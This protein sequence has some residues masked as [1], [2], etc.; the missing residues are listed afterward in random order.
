MVKVTFTFDDETVDVLR[1]TASR[2][3]KAQ[4]AVVREAIVDYASRADRLSDEER[5]HLL[6]IFDRVVPAIP[7]SQPREVNAELASIRKARH[8]SGRRTPRQ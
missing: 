7:T 4:S 5:R 2:L 3:G 1:R 6:R 8:G